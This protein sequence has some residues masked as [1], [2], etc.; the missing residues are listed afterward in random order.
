[1]DTVAK[2]VFDSK[3]LKWMKYVVEV[4]SDPDNKALYIE[5]FEA[6]R[7]RD[8]ETY[9]RSLDGYY[10]LTPEEREAWDTA[11]QKDVRPGKV[12]RFTA[13]WVDANENRPPAGKAGSLCSP[14]TRCKDPLHCCGTATPLDAYDIS[15]T[16]GAVRSLCANR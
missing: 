9:K 2:T 6:E 10:S 4:C 7:I 11:Y 5:C 8:Y 14:E 16:A 12:A 13:E 1:M 15:T 3:Y